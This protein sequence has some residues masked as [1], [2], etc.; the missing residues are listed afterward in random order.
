MQHKCGEG[1]EQT[2]YFADCVCWGVCVFL[3]MC[4]FVEL[5]DCVCVCVLRG[6]WWSVH[7]CFRY[8]SAQAP[9]STASFLQAKQTS[10][11]TCFFLLITHS[12]QTLPYNVKSI[13]WASHATCF[14][15]QADL[16]WN[17][18]GGPTPYRPRWAG[19]SMSSRR[20]WV[21]NGDAYN[22]VHS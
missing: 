6:L 5:S 20:E 22:R 19:M 4:I 12:C 7:E 2:A 16:T 18:A 3:C 10:S 8:T 21:S 11:R 15:I 1:W 17:E 14:P 9:V 13:S